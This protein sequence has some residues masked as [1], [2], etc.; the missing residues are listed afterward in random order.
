MPDVISL[1]YKSK[2][3][4]EIKPC[5]NWT[6]KMFHFENVVAKHV[7]FLEFFQVLQLEQFTLMFHLTQNYI[8]NG[9]KSLG[10]KIFPAVFSSK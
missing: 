9:E 7:A 1:G 4:L 6:I 10:H 3:N 5:L 8:I 2:V